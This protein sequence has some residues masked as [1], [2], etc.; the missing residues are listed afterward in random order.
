MSRRRGRKAAAMGNYL[1]PKEKKKIRTKRE[2]L[3]WES[4]INERG[5]K[6]YRTDSKRKKNTKAQVKRS[7][8][9]HGEE[10]EIE[11]KK[12]DRGLKTA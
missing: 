3:P 7:R 2:D 8:K 6:I 4:S 5:R 11:G 9:N 12:R 1:N 10:E